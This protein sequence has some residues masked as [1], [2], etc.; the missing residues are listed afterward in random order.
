[1]D[2]MG[3][4]TKDTIYGSEDGQFYRLAD[5][6]LLVTTA[7]NL[8]GTDHISVSSCHRIRYG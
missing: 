5:A 8:A 4:I 7:A 2:Q 1:M 6:Q 3:D